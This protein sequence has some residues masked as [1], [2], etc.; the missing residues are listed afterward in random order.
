MSG[1]MRLQK[2]VFVGKSHYRRGFK[3]H[4]SKEM[5]LI[6]EFKVLTRLFM[7]KVLVGIIPGVEVSPMRLMTLLSHCKAPFSRLSL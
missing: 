1:L 5:D 7:F 6:Q 4:H 3:R 2:Y